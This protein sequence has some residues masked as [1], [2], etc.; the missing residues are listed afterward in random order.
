MLQVVAAD[1]GISSAQAGALTSIYFLIYTAMQLPPGLIGDRI[2]IK[3]MLV[4]TYTLA[5]LGMLAVGLLANSYLTL[6]LCIGLHALGAGTY[7]TSA[8]STTMLTVPGTMRGFA[9]SI[10]NTG[11]AIG[12]ALGLAMSGPVYLLTQNWRTSFLLLAVPTLAM[13]L[14]FACTLRDVRPQRRKQ[15]SLWSI[16]RDRQLMALNLAAFCSLYGF[17]VVITWA[18]TFF[19]TER[20]LSLAVAGSY[21]AIVAVASLPMGMLLSRI[22]DRMGRKRVSLVLLPLAAASI[23]AM[24][25]VRSVEALV[26]A[27]LLYGLVGKLT[28]D[29][30][31]I[32]WV[33]DMVAQTKPD[34]FGT[35]IGVFSTIGISAAIVGPFLSGWIRDISGSLE[36]AFYL[37]AVVVL[38][39]FLFALVPRETV[40]RPVLERR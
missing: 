10:I 11:M 40:R 1:F 30:I 12:L 22:S 18:P 6:A 4:F 7:Y 16:V 17:F 3:R 15:T 24:A 25:Y 27:L 33:G 23:F 37:G 36:G 5:G 9:S 32:A 38:L 35:A 26:A 39:G 2:G 21:T 28:W 13:A 14:V 29:P 31:S 19:Q 34:A 20:A 8:Y